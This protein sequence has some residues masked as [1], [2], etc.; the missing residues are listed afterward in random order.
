[1]GNQ[2]LLYK[3]GTRSGTYA[4]F[5]FIPLFNAHIPPQPQSHDSHN[6][7]R[8]LV[9]FFSFKTHDLYRKIQK[10]NENQKHRKNMYYNLFQVWRF[11]FA[12]KLQLK[13]NKDEKNSKRR[14]FKIETP[15]EQIYFFTLTFKLFKASVSLV[16]AST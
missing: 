4:N 5:I 11:F 16:P 14:G 12:E 2:D 7:T 6:S 1:L 13:I 8:L 10:Q 15:S 3:S 9:S